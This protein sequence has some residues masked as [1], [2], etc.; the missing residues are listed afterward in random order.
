MI[1]SLLGSMKQAVEK[2]TKAN[3]TRPTKKPREWP[4]L[5]LEIPEEAP[6]IMR[7]S[8]TIVD[9][10]NGHAKLKNEGEYVATQNLLREWWGR[11]VDLRQ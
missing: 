7:D 8:K 1:H 3:G 4:P 6:D 2:K 10:V 9:W 11:G 5:E